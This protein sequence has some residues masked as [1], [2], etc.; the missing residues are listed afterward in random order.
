M[1]DGCETELGRQHLEDHKATSPAIL[2]SS[3]MEKH[4]K[5]KFSPTTTLYSILNYNYIIFPLTLLSTFYGT[6]CAIP[7]EPANLTAISKFV[8]KTGYY[9]VTPSETND[10]NWA[11]AIH[12]ALNAFFLLAQCP[13]YAHVWGLCLPMRPFEY[14]QAPKRR[15]VRAL[16]VCLVTK[17]SNFQVR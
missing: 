2:T 4:T 3:K 10:W 17:G 1:A 15:A 6:T 9:Y 7:L 12:I 11:T 14:A 5:A 13:P 8:Q 16:R